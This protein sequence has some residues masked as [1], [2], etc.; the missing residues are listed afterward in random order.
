MPKCPQIWLRARADFLLHPC[1]IWCLSEIQFHGYDL[2]FEALCLLSAFS[3]LPQNIWRHY[4][5]AIIINS[6]QSEG[7][8]TKPDSPHLSSIKHF[9]SPL[10]QTFVTPMNIACRN[11]MKAVGCSLL[12]HNWLCPKYSLRLLSGVIQCFM[13]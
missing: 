12:Q 7:C 8:I 6:L 10:A 1:Q 2:L 4:Y 5:V 3:V 11:K 13:G 9:A